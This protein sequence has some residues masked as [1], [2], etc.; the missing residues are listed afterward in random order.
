M[1]IGYP[2]SSRSK[3]MHV[4]LHIACN[5]NGTDNLEE[6]CMPARI[7][8]IVWTIYSVVL[9]VLSQYLVRFLLQGGEELISDF[10]PHVGIL[11]TDIVGYAIRINRR[12]PRPSS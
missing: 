8:I 7:Q 11:F 2:D 12:Y 6:V 10:H 1:G 3:A 9:V 4:F 5:Q